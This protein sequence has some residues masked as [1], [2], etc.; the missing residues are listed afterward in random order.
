ML[1]TKI[2][3]SGL[4]H[5]GGLCILHRSSSVASIAESEIM[6]DLTWSWNMG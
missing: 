5:K 1:G 2:V 3:L 4:L 6:K